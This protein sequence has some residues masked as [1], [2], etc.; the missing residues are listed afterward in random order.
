MTTISAGKGTYGSLAERL[1]A[2]DHNTTGFRTIDLID[3]EVI[4]AR[5]TKPNGSAYENLAARLNAGDTALATVRGTANGAI[6]ATKII[7]DTL[8]SSD[9]TA[10]L[11][12]LTGGVIK[13]A[14][15]NAKSEAIASAK[16]YADNNKI[17][18][19]SLA[20]NYDGVAD[21]VLSGAKGKDLNDRLAAVE[22]EIEGAHRS[23]VSNDSL[24]TRLDSIESN[25]TGIGN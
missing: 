14:I 13:T 9:G 22:G 23:G 15:A 4:N 18:K 12:G 2:I 1:N 25:I 20:D 21:T 5:G 24:D 16:T 17:A 7:N 3:A 19:S 10:V 11:G 6:Q 8:D